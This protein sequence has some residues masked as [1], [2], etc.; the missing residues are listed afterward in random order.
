MLDYD[1][2]S[3]GIEPKK[4]GL[5]LAALGVL[6]VGLYALSVMVDYKS[7]DPHYDLEHMSEETPAGMETPDLWRK[8]ETK[9]E[10]PPKTTPPIPARSPTT[11]PL[12]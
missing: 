3:S 9:T 8:R 6:G 1:A 2:Q 5:M 10:D 11:G 7:P 12:D 4:A